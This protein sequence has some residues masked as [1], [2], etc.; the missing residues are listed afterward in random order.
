MRAPG[1][2]L[3]VLALVVCAAQDSD[4]ERLGKFNPMAP[5]NFTLGLAAG[6]EVDQQEAGPCLASVGQ[7]V[8]FV[9][10]IETDIGALIDQH[11][12]AGLLAIHISELVTAIVNSVPLCQYTTIF[13]ALEQLTWQQVLKNA[14]AHVTVLKANGLNLGACKT[15][16]YSCGQS[17]GKIFRYLFAWGI[18]AP[19]QSPGNFFSGLFQ[20]L[21]NT[22]N[23]ADKCVED[24]TN[25][26]GLWTQT[27]Q[28]ITNLVSGDVAASFAVIADFKSLLSALQGDSQDCNLPQLG[29][30]LSGLLTPQ[31]VTQ[32]V[33]NF[34]ANM[35]GI[36]Q[37][38]AGLSNCGS[39]ESACG[40]SVGEVLRL[41]LGWGI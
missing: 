20:G 31:G 30:T 12:S 32:L 35:E 28:D 16:A 22:P 33:S 37:A 39:N 2:L 13:P 3:C 9:G 38:S 29:V 40:Y 27:M 14:A 7:V 11:G 17:L 6:L 23:G 19:Q 34:Q 26:Q 8:G 10:N 18:Y 21:E 5:L 1:L 24:L 36:L 15:N 4:F 25:L 41:V